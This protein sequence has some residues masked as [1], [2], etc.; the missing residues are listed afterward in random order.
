M[1]K[2]SLLML[3]SFFS[4]THRNAAKKN[5]IAPCPKSPNMTAKRNGNV[6]MV[7]TAGFTC[8]G[9]THTRSALGVGEQPPA[10]LYTRL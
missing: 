7:N 9:N 1:L 3:A 6:T 4:F 2:I 10:S 5:I 8:G